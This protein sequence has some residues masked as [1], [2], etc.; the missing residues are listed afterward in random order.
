MPA[1]ALRQE[2]A[3][4]FKTHHT[5]SDTF[6]KVYADEINQT[7]KVLAA[8]AYNVAMLPECLARTPAIPGPGAPSR[9]PP[10]P[11]RQPPHPP[12]CR[13]PRKAP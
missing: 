2:L 4:Y 6:D 7:A 1:F 13:P 10:S 11:S 5:E 12:R 8:W 3:D 9:T